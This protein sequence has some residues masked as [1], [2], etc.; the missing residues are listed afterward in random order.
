[1]PQPISPTET[2]AILSTHEESIK[3]LPSQQRFTDSLEQASEESSSEEQASEESSSDSKGCFAYLCAIFT[4]FFR[5]LFCMS[6]QKEAEEGKAEADKSSLPLENQK[7]ELPPSTQLP[8]GP[9]GPKPADA[10]PAPLPQTPSP[11]PMPP[12]PIISI[13]P[14][15][16]AQPK[17]PI[18]YTQSLPVLDQSPSN[19]VTSDVE[20]ENEEEETS[21]SSMSISEEPSVQKQPSTT[22]PLSPPQLSLPPEL[23]EKLSVPISSTQPPDELQSTSSSPISASAPILVD[24]DQERA[25]RFVEYFDPGG[26]QTILATDSFCNA[27]SM[28]NRAQE[29]VLYFLA[30]RKQFANLDHYIAW[31]F[32]KNDEKLQSK[33]LI[34]GAQMR[35]DIF[36]SIYLQDINKGPL[37]E[38]DP[39]T[40]SEE[41]LRKLMKIFSDGLPTYQDFM[42]DPRWAKYSK[43][44][45]N[46]NLYKRYLS[47]SS[48]KEPDPSGASMKFFEDH[49]NIQGAAGLKAATSHFKEYEA[50]PKVQNKILE[51]ILLHAH[52][53][54]ELYG[55]L[56]DYLSEQVLGRKRTAAFKEQFKQKVG[57]PFVAHRFR[58][59]K[60]QILEIFKG[61]F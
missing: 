8:Q 33:G 10:S 14:P 17:P 34:K 25:R 24:K 15:D 52:T 45:D 48:F 59:F 39:E 1:M 35:S 56:E 6:K 26:F 5:W 49:F 41:E 9:T 23:I 43:D 51:A 27:G 40:W 37:Q 4:S 60:T 53:N 18:P 30:E 7:L 21:I 20:I 57:L 42:S 2:R 31:N 54:T 16:I 61:D 11:N 3:L 55:I 58:T 32:L 50:H 19:I 22:Q 29:W 44:M 47:I 12:V 36:Y 38:T 28:T 13:L 46:D